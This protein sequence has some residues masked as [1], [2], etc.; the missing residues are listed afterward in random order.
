MNFRT[1]EMV[2]RPTHG[3]VKYLLLQHCCDHVESSDTIK[4]LDFS[5]GSS[6]YQYV[7]LAWSQ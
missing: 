5:G 7:W 2:W 4:D 3:V 1:I 6:V